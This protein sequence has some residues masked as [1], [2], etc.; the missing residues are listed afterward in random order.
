MKILLFNTSDARGGAAVA[1]VRL[2]EALQSVGAEVRMLVLN[3]DSSRPEVEALHG[4]KWG[5]LAARGAFVAERLH[6]YM[7]NGRDRSRLFHVS[8]ALT[9]HDISRHP[10]V[11]WADVLHLHWVNQGFL[12]LRGLERLSRCGKPVV[13]TM[14]DMWP[15]TAICHH[16]RECIRYQTIC[17][18]CPQI[19]SHREH[20]LAHRV[21]IRKS[22]V[23]S[24]LRPT[25]VGCSHWLADL[26]RKS[27]LTSELRIESIPNP[28]DTNLFTPGSRTA[29]REALGLPMDKTL[30]LFGAVQAD[31]P[32]KGIYE[33]SQAMQCLK[34]DYPDQNREVRLVVFGTLREEVH[35]LFP[36][37]EIIPVGYVRDPHRMAELYR[38]A[39]LFV[40]P[41]LEENLP[42]TIM[43]SLSVGTPCIAFRV[44]GIPQMIV[45]G[46]TGYLAEYRQASDLAKGMAETITMLGRSRESVATDCRS[47]VMTHY[48]RQAVADRMMQL[49]RELV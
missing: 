23:L 48:S 45:Q 4:G 22:Q 2:M 31:D 9:G 42:N 36:D 7:C 11:Q 15:V 32:R 38:A 13:W 1:A 6:I 5:R 34:T 33:L 20:D 17:E 3:Q 47:F 35:K 10:W 29:A 49:Y 37:H 28:I 40:T 41:S 14:H 21:W 19:S 39:D 24:R 12:S 26:A 44:G 43:E 30:I 16:A 46:S 25:L 8:T 18:A 27:A